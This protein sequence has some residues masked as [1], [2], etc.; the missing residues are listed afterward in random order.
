MRHKN[1]GNEK[2]KAGDS[3]FKK[4]YWLLERK[5][6][7]LFAFIIRVLTSWFSELNV[8]RWG[9]KNWN[10]KNKNDCKFRSRV[11]RHQR[12]TSPSSRLNQTATLWT[13]KKYQFERLFRVTHTHTS[14]CDTYEKIRVMCS[15]ICTGGSSRKH[16]KNFFANTRESQRQKP[17]S[18]IWRHVN[19]T[20]PLMNHIKSPERMHSKNSSRVGSCR[21]IRK[22]DRVDSPLMHPELCSSNLGA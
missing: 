9:E 22:T 1:V 10:E 18:R 14:I 16:R 21:V 15:G 5:N 2:W 4:I 20:P 8:S 19:N 17:V 6:L 11:E 13:R 7:E 12:K 3:L